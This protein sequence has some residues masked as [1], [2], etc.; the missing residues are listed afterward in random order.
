MF[1]IV[2]LKNI[3][4]IIVA[5]LFTGFVF[6]V[7]LGLSHQTRKEQI[8][9]SPYPDG[10]NYAFTITDD[11]DFRKVKKVRPIYDFLLEKGFK[12]TVAVW[13]KEAIKSNGLPEKKRFYDFGDTCQR[14]GFLAFHKRLQNEGFEIA[15]H[16]VSGG[17]DY[18]NDTKEGYEEFKRLFGNYP[19]INIM[20]SNNLENIYWGKNVFKNRFLQI[21]TRLFYRKSKLP[22]SGEQEESPYFWGDICKAK[23][24]YVR[25][26]G[27]SDINT[28]KFNP[29]M[30][31]HDPRK[32]YV[33]YWFSFS[34]GY[35]VKYFNKLLSDKNIRELV[36]ERGTCIVYTHFSDG[37]CD[38][39]K[40]G[41]YVVNNTTKIQL[42]KLSK[43]KDG[44]FVPA[45]EILDRLL[46]MKNVVVHD[47]GNTILVSN[48]NDFPVSGVTLMTKPERILY[49]DTGD[50][51][52]ANSEGEILIGELNNREVL[53][54]FTDRKNKYVTNG[55]LS[56]MENIRLIYERTKILFFSHKG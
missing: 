37:F 29:S 8:R 46:A 38:K 5:G 16:T 13:V 43:Q 31:Y 49:G 33:N 32:P 44:W 54:L 19:K 23:T 4:I 22:F 17:N 45:S 40:N 6:A 24:K 7:I 2:N 11:P 26:W 14:K 47:A 53:P 39:Q 25:M 52:K 41:S 55:R 27:T 20:H 42:E 34:D 21:M 18:R 15:L 48:T 50:V 12:T 56:F 9:V 51:Y 3:K 1:R 30:P 36:R 10:M 35:N 28:L